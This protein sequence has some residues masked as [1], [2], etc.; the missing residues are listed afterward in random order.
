MTTTT[1][2]FTR[3]DIGCYF[4]SARGTYI[5]EAIQEM[6]QAHGWKYLPI[7]PVIYVADVGEG[8]ANDSLSYHEATTEAED[9]L[10]T[11]TAD[12]VWFGPT[13][14]GDWGLWHLCDDDM[15]C[16]FCESM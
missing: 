10:N 5:G 13:E 6:A 7:Y 4:D 3:D 8:H 14:S 1:H 15:S 16:D 2:V 9:F 12:D 11:L